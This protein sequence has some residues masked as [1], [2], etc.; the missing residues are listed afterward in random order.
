MTDPKCDCG[1]SATCKPGCPRYE[2]KVWD[3]QVDRHTDADG[4]VD[5]DAF[6][7]ES[8]ANQRELYRAAPE[9]ILQHGVWYD[10]RDTTDALTS[11]LADER[12]KVVD[13]EMRYGAQAAEYKLAR[14]R[15][16]VLADERIADREKVAAM[17]MRVCIATGHGDTIDTLLGTL[18]AAIVELQVKAEN[19]YETG[20][21]AG[22]AGKGER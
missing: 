20:Y 1:D 3:A 9:T 19:A 18:E 2:Q 22:H 15:L 8:A 12:K 14:E 6:N 10:R 13:W 21:K 4:N 7:A 16:I 17:M 5:I 11:L